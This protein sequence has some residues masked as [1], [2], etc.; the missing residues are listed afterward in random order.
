[1]FILPGQFEVG[2]KLDSF[3]TPFRLRIYELPQDNPRLYIQMHLNYVL[4]IVCMLTAERR[5][6]LVAMD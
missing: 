6:W 2:R 3:Q 5:Y 4:N 1:M